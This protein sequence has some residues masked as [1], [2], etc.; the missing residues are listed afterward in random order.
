M[1]EAF[2]IMLWPFLACLLLP[3]ILVYLGLHIVRR[4]IIFVDLALAQVAAMGICLAILLGHDA[5]AWQTTA[6]SAA[7]TLV[8]AG[9]LTLTRPSGRRVPQEA[10][11]GIVYVVAA[12]AS[13]LLLS[14]S[15]EG[16]EELRRTLV[17]EI[18]LVRP[19]EVLRTFALFVAVGAVHFVFRR[20]FLLLSFNPDRGRSEGLRLWFWD[21]LFYALFGVVVTSFVRMG[22]VFLAFSFLII[23]AVCA[24]LF[25]KSLRTQLAVG[26]AVATLS[27]IVGLVASYRLDLPTGAAV[28]CALGLSLLLTGIGRGIGFMIKR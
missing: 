19:D 24:N 23:P 7:F 14:R 21:F 1:S 16:N 17:G 3:G 4:E 11:I 12:A 26:W 25:A 8:G 9:V 22:G 6:W 2:Q 5:H 28:V 15:P 10:L 20:P 13:F 27:S 18:L